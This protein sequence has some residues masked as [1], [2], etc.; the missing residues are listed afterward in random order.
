ML[1]HYGMHAYARFHYVYLNEVKSVANRGHFN[2]HY[3]I[4]LSDYTPLV[5]LHFV[6][7]LLISMLVH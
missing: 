7:T 6:K 1:I 3:F 5:N 4:R 2:N